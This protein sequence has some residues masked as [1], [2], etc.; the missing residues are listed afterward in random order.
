MVYSLTSTAQ[1]CQQVAE[2]RRHNS[3]PAVYKN[4]ISVI[5]LMSALVTAVLCTTNPHVI[6][7]LCTTGF[8]ATCQ[9][10]MDRMDQSPEFRFLSKSFLHPPAG[11]QNS[12][13]VFASEIGCDV[14]VN[15]PGELPGQQHG[16]L[17]WDDDVLSPVPLSQSADSDAELAGD[18]TSDLLQPWRV[19][20]SVPG[21]HAFGHAFVDHTTT[22]PGQGF[23]LSKG[24]QKV[25]W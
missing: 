12:C 23:Q 6:N 13:V 3:P 8:L 20:R 19:S 22:Y 11:V 2:N 14:R 5:H 16:T 25:S 15:G 1:L 18:N 21:D 24:G 4:G 10:G 9:F 7:R 17:P